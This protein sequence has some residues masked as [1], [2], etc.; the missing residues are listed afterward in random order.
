[1]KSLLEEHRIKREK[2]IAEHKQNELL[3]PRVGNVRKWQ[4]DVFF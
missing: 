2:A 4:S 3:G 1:M